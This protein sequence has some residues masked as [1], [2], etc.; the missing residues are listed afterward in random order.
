[1]LDTSMPIQILVVDDEPSIR[2]LLRRWIERSMHA[3][4]YEAHDGLQ[5]LEMAS[6]G[7]IELIISDLNMPVLDGIDM[8]S[9]LQADPA[10]DRIEVIVASHIAAEEKI[11]KVIS[12]GVSDYFLKPL[13]YDWVIQRL[14]AAS[15]RIIERRERF[16]AEGDRSRTHVLVAD[17]DPNFCAF[18]ESALSGD[19]SVQTSRTMAEILVKVLRTKPDAIL[20]SGDVPGLKIEFMLERLMGMPGT[21]PPQVLVLADPGAPKPDAEGITGVVKKT[22][23]PETL[24]GDVLQLLQGGPAPAHGV[25]GWVSALEGELVTAL[26][27]AFGMM[28]GVEPSVLDSPK[29]APDHD[30]FGYIYIND[31]EG[32]FEMRIDLRS[33]REFAGALMEAMLGEDPGG[34]IQYD[35]VQEILNVVSG[36]LKNSCL[37]R[38]IDVSIGLPEVREEDPGE[39]QNA[40]FHCQKYCDW[41]GGHYFEL[42]FRARPIQKST[43]PLG[44][45]TDG[46]PEAEAV[47]AG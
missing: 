4:V 29:D 9:L 28:A 33:K 44:G 3:E 32:E 8:L 37:E 1:M 13:Q 35:A 46:E 31:D 19:F 20:L 18:A 10:R 38:K 34:E 47:E 40:H 45:A 25:L 30:L 27:Q 26:F 17:P 11:R 15:D 24:L 23:V 14:K 39:L 7:K 6:A 5:G 41:N 2:L 21:E 43:S 12:M 22:F 42:D 16:S 36:R